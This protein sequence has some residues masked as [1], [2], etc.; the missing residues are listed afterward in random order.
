MIHVLSGLY[1]S[2]M[3]CTL[4]ASLKLLAVNAFAGVST[5]SADE[6]AKSIEKTFMGFSLEK[7]VNF[8]IVFVL[9]YII[10]KIVLAVLYKM[11]NH[12]TL[13]EKSISGFLKPTLKVVV[14]FVAF[15]IAAYQCGA[16]V[17]SVLAIFSIMG[18][19][20]S[21][22]IQDLLG[23]FFSG[24]SILATKPIHIDDFVEIGSIT[25]TVKKIDL[26]YTI[27]TTTANRVVY[28]Q[29]SQVCSNNI[30]N[31]SVNPDCRIVVKITAA[32]E[33]PVESV[34][35]ALADAVS[36]CDFKSE[37]APYITISS[38]GTSSVEYL[39]R[40]WFAGSPDYNAETIKYK[41][42]EE[43]AKSFDEAG[44]IMTYDHLNVHMTD[45]VA[46]A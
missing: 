38:F 23:N 32:Y 8:L 39:V 15:T 29:N 41:L 22:S 18:L 10:A 45:T 40:V 9:A 28:I 4:P 11:V 33:S 44:V 1:I 43:I 2:G 5:S 6:T 20:I 35:A 27:I 13:M 34:K 24:L 14:Y 7:L 26:I 37:P 12:S 46:K 36:H 42:N 17:S 21:L 16:N 25:G 3:S 19:A 30:T 31:Y